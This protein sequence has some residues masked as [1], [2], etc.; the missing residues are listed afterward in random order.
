MNN[1]LKQKVTATVVA[2][3]LPALPAMAQG[4]V[5]ESTEEL[6][7]GLLVAFGILF[8]VI[9]VIMNNVIKGLAGNHKLWKSRNEGD[10]TKAGVIVLL[11]MWSG[12]AMAVSPD[13]SVIG[14]LGQFSST[15]WMLVMID[16]FLALVIIAQ[17]RIFNKLIEALR[18]KDAPKTEPEVEVVARPQES[19]V[20]KKIMKMLT[21]SVPV[22]KEEEVLT[23][24]EYDGIRE[25]DNVLPPW[26]VAMFY[27]SILF[28]FVYIIHY[29]VL[30]TG[31]LQL[32]EYKE[33]VLKG[34][35][36]VA[37]FRALAGEQVDEINVTLVTDA[38]R[39]RNGEKIY[40]QHCVTCHGNQ[41]EGGVGP[42]FTDAYWIHGGSIN[43]LFTTVKYGVPSKGMISWRQQL[44]PKDMQDVSSFILTFQGTDPPNQKEPQGELYIPDEKSESEPETNEDDDSGGEDEPNESD[45]GED[46]N[47]EES[48]NE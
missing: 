8:L 28:A 26:W 25:L 23:D 41:A 31:D 1:S 29:H 10:G 42:N 3:L 24:H 43:D 45:E 9:I 6:L 20:M 7:Y 22:E 34:E 44:S 48:I 36:Q 12:S 27:A 30:E 37:A 40:F 33:S 15:F 19:V 11:T 17:L 13:A 5:A 16:L 47:D 2:L 46:T 35:E 18:E 38:S 39:L 32:A 4:G 21:K 14:V